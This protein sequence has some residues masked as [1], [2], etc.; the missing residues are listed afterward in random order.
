[1]Y[2]TDFDAFRTVMDRLGV[3]FTKAVSD[4]LMSAYWDALKDQ[5]LQA[6]REKATSHE[7]H[8]KF[9]PKP[10]ELRP[11]DD[12]PKVDPRN[13]PSFIDGEKRATIN[14]DELCHDNPSRWLAIVRP[15]VHEVGKRKGMS[16]FE[17]ERKLQAYVEALA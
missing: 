10:H 16:E 3:V 11:K 15:N 9:F 13:D 2:S 12:K 14:L 1:M 5:P 7:R 8:G 4:E 6:F 17:I